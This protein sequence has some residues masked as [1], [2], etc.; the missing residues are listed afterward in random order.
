MAKETSSTNRFTV[1]IIGAGTGGLCLAHGLRRAGI[2]VAVHERDR[3]RSDGLL[4]YRVGIDA[5]GSRA[6]AACLPPELF[7]TF[8]ATCA[9]PPRYFTMLT[10]KFDPLLTLEL[11]EQDDAIDSEVG[12]PDDPAPGAA[13]RRRRLRPSREVLHPLRKAA[14]WPGDRVLRGRHQRHRGRAGRGGRHALPGPPAISA[15][16]DGRWSAPAGI[17]DYETRMREYG[18][19]AVD[20][21][22]KSQGPDTALQRPVLGRVALAGLRTGIRMVD[23]L[24]PLRRKFLAG[25]YADRCAGPEN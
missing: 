7:D 9:R 1:L 23:R 6:L 25:L 15:A 18:F 20:A 3:A 17:G 24:P 11:P 22:L 14:G 16:R 13:D 5:D 12:Q 2:D 21:S 4:G 8:V 10:E 19:A